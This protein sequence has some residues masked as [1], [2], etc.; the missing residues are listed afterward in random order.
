MLYRSYNLLTF[1][2]YIMKKFEIDFYIIY[3]II[4]L[5]ISFTLLFHII[6]SFAS[7]Q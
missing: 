4:L 2:I 3:N 1:D 5:I 7:F 6:S